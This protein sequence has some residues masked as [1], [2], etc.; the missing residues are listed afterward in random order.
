M[1]HQYQITIEIKLNK[2]D[3]NHLISRLEYTG[4]ASRIIFGKTGVVKK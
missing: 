4:V 2:R 1:E 3:L